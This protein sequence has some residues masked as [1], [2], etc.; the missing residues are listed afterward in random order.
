MATIHQYMGPGTQPP[1]LSAATFS[2]DAFDATAFSRVMVD[3][4]VISI[5]GTSVPPKLERAI[6]GDGGYPTSVMDAGSAIST[7]DTHLHLYGSE[8]TTGNE[9]LGWM[10]VTVTL[11]SVSALNLNIRALF[12]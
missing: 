6:D 8:L 10:R 11:T 1:S 9:V 12:K 5:T 7:D 4:H 2:T 3:C